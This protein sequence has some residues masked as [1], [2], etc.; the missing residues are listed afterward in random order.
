MAVDRVNSINAVRIELKSCEE[1]ALHFG[2][3]IFAIRE[4]ELSF[5]VKMFS[6]LDG[7]IYLIEIQFD[8]Y[9][10]WPLCIE[11][12]DP[13]NGAIDTKNAYPAGKIDNFFL[14][15]NGMPLICHPSSR[16]AYSSLKGPH[17]RPFVD[18]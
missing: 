17:E 14:V 3:D 1:N 8:N 7:E 6:P 13:L 11:F 9:K 12:I 5:G 18:E 2:W 15:H 10:E 4:E 16:K